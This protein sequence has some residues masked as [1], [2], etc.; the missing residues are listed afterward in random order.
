MM[1]ILTVTELAKLTPLQLARLY[2]EVGKGLPYTRLQ[3]PE[4]R[5]IEES[6]ANIRFVVARRHVRPR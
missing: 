1:K 2:Q 6:L 3:T 4:R 5:A